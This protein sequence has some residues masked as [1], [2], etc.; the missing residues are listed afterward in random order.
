MYCFA[1]FYI[2]MRDERPKNG[3]MT[4]LEVPRSQHFIDGEWISARNKGE[5]SV[6]DPATHEVLH[7]VALAEPEDVA[8]AVDAARRAAPGWA[9][10]SATARGQLLRRWADLIMANVENLA[11]WE[12][13]DV[14]KPLSGGRMNMYITHSIVEYF[15]GAADKM[16]GVTLPTRS[17]D[18]LGYTVREPYGVCGVITPWNVPALL[19]MANV[20]PA[21]A[22]GNTVVLKPSEI[23]PM[24]PLA[25]I[26]LARQAGFPPGVLNAVVGAADAGAAL[27]SN[28]GIKHISFVGSTMTGKAVMR[29]AADNLVPVKLELGGKSPNVVFADADLD[30]AIPGIVRGITENA[31]QNCNAGSRLLLEDSIKDEA[32]DRIV[33]A[34][35]QIRVGAWHEDLDMGPLVS[36]AQ[37]DKVVGHLDSAKG[38]GARAVVGGQ[39]GEGWFVQPTVF[40]QVDSSMNIVREEVFGPVLTVQT[41]N[42]LQQATEM[43]ND[44]EFGLMA[45]VWTNDVSVALRLAQDVRAGQVTVNQFG[46]AGVI[47]FPF[48]MQK[49]SGFGT[50]GYDS[51]LEY[52]QEKAVGIKLL[53]R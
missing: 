11:A 18:Y 35:Q 41:F 12:A 49:D 1:R 25:L 22:A 24:S 30:N 32:L 28:P 5:L 34:M 42:G 51:M 36:Q 17:Q 9:A 7:T 23:A 13:K 2:D 26:E 38:E 21:L 47:G 10:T 16:T 29:A 3:T 6:L 46:D 20:A 44:T 14:G 8:D 43:I 45:S 52:T 27:T 53:N 48:N 31:G 50:G 39:A 4:D 37:F 40:D 33:A 19:A 15:A